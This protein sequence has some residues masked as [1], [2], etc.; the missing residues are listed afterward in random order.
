MAAYLTLIDGSKW[1]PYGLERK[2]NRLNPKQWQAMM[3]LAKHNG[4]IS[5]Y[6]IHEEFG[7]SDEFPTDL[8]P[9]Y[10]G[11]SSVRLLF[12][13]E[14]WF[15][16]TKS[17]LSEDQKNLM[18]LEAL[19]F[20][21][22]KVYPPGDK[23][24]PELSEKGQNKF[25]ALH[26]KKNRSLIKEN[27]ILVRRVLGLSDHVNETLIKIHKQVQANELY[28]LQNKN[29]DELV[30]MKLPPHSQ[31]FDLLTGRPV[32]KIFPLNSEELTKLWWSKF[33]ELNG[34]ERFEKYGK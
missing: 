31:V 7:K 18:R 33:V 32:D 28:H 2:S 3:Y 23:Y 4:H 19:I 21:C 5:V 17:N 12:D 29:D 15:K 30:T 22:H 16:S 10:I 13:L 25:D 14:R 6:P 27:S 34:W 9:Y 11:E 20:N 24:S 1:F 8:Q 26:I